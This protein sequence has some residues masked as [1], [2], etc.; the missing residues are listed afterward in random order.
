MNEQTT[1]TQTTKHESDGRFALQMRSN[2][3]VQRQLRRDA[4]RERRRQEIIEQYGEDELL[5]A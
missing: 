4:E 1:N 2:R 5:W 3:A